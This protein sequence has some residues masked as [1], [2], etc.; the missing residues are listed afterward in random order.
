VRIGSDF[1]K[2]EFNMY[3]LELLEPNAFIGDTLI[4]LLSI[5]FAYKL[6][7][8]PLQSSFFVHWRRFFLWFGI[9]YALG[10]LGHLLYNYWAIAGKLPAFFLALLAPFFIEQAMLSIYNDSRWKSRFKRL[11][12]YKLLLSL[13]AFSL[14]CIFMDLSQD[15][16]KGLI[17]VSFSSL[18]GLGFALGYLGYKYAQDI[19]KGFYYFLVS[20]FVLLPSGFFQLLK[21]NFY[22]WFDR[23]DVSHLLMLIALVLY[24][25]GVRSYSRMQ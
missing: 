22:P 19:S 18:I 9:C 8:Y 6:Y 13:V 25:R 1:E 7:R 24:Y 16:S 20:L 21:I 15:P 14:I 10:G 11:S 17:V 4:F 3:G 5:F 12:L 23:N 2:I